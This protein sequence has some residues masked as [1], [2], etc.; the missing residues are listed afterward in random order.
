MAAPGRAS[1]AAAR[2]ATPGKLDY[3]R[4]RSQDRAITG[5]GKSVLARLL[6]RGLGAAA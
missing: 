5:H 1:P 2:E 6:L 4:F 3:S